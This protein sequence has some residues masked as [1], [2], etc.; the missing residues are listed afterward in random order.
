MNFITFIINFNTTADESVDS[1][2]LEVFKVGLNGGLSNLSLP[3]VAGL[4]EI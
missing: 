3:M 2:S 1:P 4:G